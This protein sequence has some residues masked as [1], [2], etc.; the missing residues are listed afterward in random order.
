MPHSKK[1]RAALA[2]LPALLPTL[3]AAQMPLPG[4]WQIGAQTQAVGLPLVLSPMAIE[5]C[6]TPEDAR[7]PSKLLGRL[8][9]PGASDCAYTDS[10]YVGSNFHF[11][12]AC[13]GAFGI[14]AH[15]EVAFTATTLTGSI[16]SSASL[17]GQA[18]DM[19]STISAQRLGDCPAERPG[20]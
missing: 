5:H 4:L 14:Q 17:N 10:G 7:D 8:S 13:A 6:L 15:G 16:D 19:H 11:V 9:S 18:L 12:M 1:I 3:A 20:K 2:L